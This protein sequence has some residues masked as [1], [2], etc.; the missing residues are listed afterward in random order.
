MG[1]QSFPADVA[2]ADTTQLVDRALP[3]EW[4][5]RL[6]YAIS[7]VGSPPVLAIAAIALTAAVLASPGVWLWA[8]TYVSVAVMIPMV[9]IL[10]QVRQGRLSDLDIQLRRQRA[11][12][13]L[14]SIVC[15]GLAWLIMALS[16][17]PLELAILAGALCLQMVI[18]MG[19]TL[20]WKISMHSTAAAGAAAVVW[21]LVGTPLPLLIGVPLIAWSRV[22]L[23]RHTLSQT[24]AGAALGFA[25]VSAALRFAL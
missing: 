23:R 6:A 8:M 7:M 17:A 24:V 3:R 18:V 21:S 11:R 15:S 16:A 20:R 10:W 2:E 12:P 13:L 4:D 22:R 1:S 14:L 5:G 25:V 9:Y 19:I